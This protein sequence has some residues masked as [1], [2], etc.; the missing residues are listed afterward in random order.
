MLPLDLTMHR[1]PLA[2]VKAKQALM[3]LAPGQQLLMMLSD[4]GAVQDVP[5][6]AQKQGF[7]TTVTRLDGTRVLVQLRAPDR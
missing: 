5:K 4:P 7:E 1:C 3:S 2:F 6:Y